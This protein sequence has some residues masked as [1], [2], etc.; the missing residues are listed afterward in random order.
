MYVNKRREIDVFCNLKFGTI[1]KCLRDIGKF[2]VGEKNA[3]DLLNGSGV[4]LNE[5]KGELNISIGTFTND[6]LQGT[7]LKIYED[8]EFQFGEF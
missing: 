3:K 6:C 8:G 5:K 2:E 7:G 1:G 4:W